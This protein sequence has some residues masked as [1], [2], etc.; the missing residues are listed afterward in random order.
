M[1]FHPT[2]PRGSL[3]AI[4][5]CRKAVWWRTA[6][7][8]VRDGNATARHRLRCGW[9]VPDPASTPKTARSTGAGSPGRFHT[10]ATR[11]PSAVES[12][13]S[14]SFRASIIHRED[15][16][17]L[18]R[19]PETGGTPTP[20]GVEFVRCR[21]SCGLESR[22]TAPK[23]PRMDVRA[24]FRARRGWG[25]LH[26]QDAC[27]PVGPRP[28]Y[29]RTLKP[30]PVTTKLPAGRSVEDHVRPGR[31]PRRDSPRPRPRR[32]GSG[33][34]APRSPPLLR[35]AGN[36]GVRG[37]TAPRQPPQGTHGV[38]PQWSKRNVRGSNHGRKSHKSNRDCTIRHSCRYRGSDPGALKWP[39][40]RY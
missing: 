19:K 38:W 29:G 37:G 4:S 34:G 8:N 35:R 16:E 13:A 36:A 25:G 9:P 5:P 33:G 31:R 30:S 27:H 28:A 39:E 1:H 24:V 17:F 23:T 14:T 6:K 10:R 21:R 12:D 32:R 18:G 15:V 7:T 11:S 40:K 26:G 22:R 3:R 2:L 20:P